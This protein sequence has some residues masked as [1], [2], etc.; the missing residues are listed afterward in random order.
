VQDEQDIYF[1]VNPTFTAQEA[2]VAL[3]GEAQPI[4]WDPSTGEERPIAPW[5]ASEG[6]TRFRVHLPPVGSVLILSKPP[7]GAC[8][9]ETDLVID[10]IN[11]S[12]VKGYGPGLE[13][14]VVLEQ[15]GRQTRLIAQAGEIPE[16]LLLDGEWEFQAED[17]NALVVGKWLAKSEAPGTDRAG[18]ARP[19]TE[20]SSGWLPMVPGA[21]S[22]QLP[23]E[24][25][26]AYPIP[27]WYRISFQVN[28]LPPKLEVIIDGFSGS[29][30][31]LFLNGQPVQTE[32][33]RSAIDSQMQAV[34]IT[35]LA[36]PGENLLALRLVLR[37]ATDGLLDLVKIM[38][39]FRL[40]PHSQGW[41]IAAPRRALQPAPWTDQGYPFFS[42]RGVYRHRFTLP[43]TFLPGEGGQRIFLEP[44]NGD[45]VLEVILN[46]QQA[47]VRLWP[48]YRTE[49]TGL[50]RPGENTL[51]LRAANT[52]VNLLEATARPSGLS[53]APRL[54]AYNQFVFEMGKSD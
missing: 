36:R 22:Y 54:V 44:E 20:P 18:Y 29:D 53:G 38:G 28:D 32:P 52:L 33:A 43:E 47:G 25:V 14:T 12:Q 1:L 2:N 7:V 4:L 39:D 51:E 46:D 30:W 24:P 8:V 9:I 3:T 49:I 50:L 40:E 15:E 19:E 41:A 21:W 6:R 45:D 11:S 16:P 17:A 48:P 27:V 31:Q 23:A 10:E 5:C 37:N 35:A 42:G 26:E 34:D 13:G